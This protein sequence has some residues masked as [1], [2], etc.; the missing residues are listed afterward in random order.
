M[1][2]QI[3]L[4]CDNLTKKYNDLLVL[5][6]VSLSVKKGEVVAIMGESGSGKT[7]FL[8][9][10]NFLLSSDEG[11]VWLDEQLYMKNSKPLFELNEIR[12]NIGLVFQ[13]F[14]LFPNLTC[15]E[16]ITLALR[17]ISRKTK[18]EANYMAFEMAKKFEIHTILNRYPS[19]ISGGQS[20]KIALIR[21]LILS[22]K[23][24]MLDEITSF[25]D[26]HSIFELMQ[27]LAA[28]K[29]MEQFGNISIILV[30]H[31]FNFAIEFSDRIIFLEHGKF[32][33]DHPAKLFI[34]DCKTL[35]ARAFIN[36]VIKV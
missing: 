30:T 11:N 28:I 29:K 25:L 27:I 6:K 21:A 31:N 14:N 8:K 20:Q 12:R 26:P 33:E 9:C 4:K 5:D 19:E 7:S 32:V 34:Q 15:L 10:L 35:G 24:L 13:E 23:V 22:P 36:K 1:V 3:M 16:N 17:K 2:E 18:K